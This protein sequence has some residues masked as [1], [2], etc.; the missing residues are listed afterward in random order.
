MVCIDW[1]Q[2]YY[3]FHQRTS[4]MLISLANK[5]VGLI[6]KLYELNGGLVDLVVKLVIHNSFILN[7]KLKGQIHIN[8]SSN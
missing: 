3:Y 7:H 5:Q 2:R 1:D 4:V 6:N 8:V